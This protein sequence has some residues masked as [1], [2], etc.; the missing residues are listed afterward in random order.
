MR[1]HILSPLSIEIPTPKTPNMG[2][3]LPRHFQ[4]NLG[5]SLDEKEWEAIS[6]SAPPTGQK[7]M[8]NYLKLKEGTCNL[9]G[10]WKEILDEGKK[11]SNLQL[12]VWEWAKW[13]KER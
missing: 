6:L 3:G 7:L 10:D 12:R 11:K 9:T 8:G 4:E 2:F 1:V 5:A 13:S